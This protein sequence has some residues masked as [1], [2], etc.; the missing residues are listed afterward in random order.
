MNNF[1]N[2]VLL[3]VKIASLFTS[4]FMMHRSTAVFYSWNVA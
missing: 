3:M 1:R 2:Q 4:D